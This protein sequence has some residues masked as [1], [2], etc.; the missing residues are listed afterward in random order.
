MQKIGITH[1]KP[2]RDVLYDA[3]RELRRAGGVER[4]RYDSAKEATEEGRDPLGGV[5]APENDAF[6]WEDAAMLELG[7]ETACELG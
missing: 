4:D 7:G 5:S 2:G 1:E 6:P 3:S